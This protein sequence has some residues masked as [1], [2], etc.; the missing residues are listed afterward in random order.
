MTPDEP[1]DGPVLPGD[2]PT[3]YERYLEVDD[4]LAVQKPV[5]EL[6]HHDERL[7]QTVHQ[8]AELWFHQALFEME[9][10]GELIADGEI[11]HARRL[12]DRATWAIRVTTEQIH[13]LETM[14][15]W[16]FHV[17][18][19]GL[20]QGSGAESPG[21]RKIVERVPRIFGAFEELLQQRDVELAEV[22]TDADEHPEL[23]DLAESLTDF[24]M[25]FSIWR[26]DHL[27]MIK[28]VIGR[29]VKSLQGYTVHQLEED[30]QQH[31][32][33][34]LWDVRIELTERAGT[35]PD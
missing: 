32:F 17:I 10:A 8:T 11:A 5:D 1:E 35:S 23:F 7:F 15:P 33:P 4:L 18:R 14:N 20:G 27:G 30:V 34:E 13:I 3:D 24:D 2:A 31:L 9:T 22:Y 6:N 25:F 12:I 16:D 29:D 28:R 26:T 19:R 21:F